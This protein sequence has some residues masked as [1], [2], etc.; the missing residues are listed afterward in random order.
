MRL[1]NLF[2]QKAVTTVVLAL[3]LLGTIPFTVATINLLSGPSYAGGVMT[4]T[5]KVNG[6][7]KS[8][9]ES[10]IYLVD[11][12]IHQNLKY[13]STS[14]TYYMLTTSAIAASTPFLISIET[15]TAL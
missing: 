9:T 12:P 1:L 14:N 8:L 6:V 11:D 4:F 3:M 15:N 13:D 2:K 10:E 5:G 7:T